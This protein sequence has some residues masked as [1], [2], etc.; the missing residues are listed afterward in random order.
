MNKLERNELAK[1]IKEYDEFNETIESIIKFVK[2][3][4][5]VKDKF[6]G[7]EKCNIKLTLSFGNGSVSETL[8]VR[9][10]SEIFQSII[11]EL[12]ILK[13]KYEEQLEEL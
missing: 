2:L 7:Q 9:E 4:D 3:P 12:K 10:D 13:E 6:N 5:Y 8:I 11:S 1:K